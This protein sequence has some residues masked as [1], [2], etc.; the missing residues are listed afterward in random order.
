[1]ESKQRGIMGKLRQWFFR[2]LDNQVE[3]SL[4]RSADKQFKKGREN[5]TI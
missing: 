2:W 5:D 4:Q 3:K 1:M